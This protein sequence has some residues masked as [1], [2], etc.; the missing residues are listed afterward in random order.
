MK[1]TSRLSTAAEKKTIITNLSSQTK[2]SLALLSAQTKD[3]RFLNLEKL[4]NKLKMLQ[5][6]ENTRVCYKDDETNLYYPKSSHYRKWY[7]LFKSIKILINS[8]VNEAKYRNIEKFQ[9]FY[10]NID[11]QESNNIFGDILYSHND[12][13]ETPR[14]SDILFQSTNVATKPIETCRAG[15]ISHHI[16]EE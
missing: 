1:H 7:E 12:D 8:Q 6:S 5:N 4:Q 14:F 11:T 9:D 13:Q 2:T 3:G 16:V 10:Q 15:E